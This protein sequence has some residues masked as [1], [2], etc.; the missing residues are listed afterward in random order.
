MPKQVTIIANPAFDA[1]TAADKKIMADMAKAGGR[2]VSYQTALENIRN[3]GG[4]YML[5]PDQEQGAAAAPAVAPSLQ[6]MPSRDLKIMMLQL[7]I[8]TEKQ[9]QRSDIIKLIEKKLDEVDVIEDD[10]TS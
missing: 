1:K 6:D 7:G 10:E 4:M 9:M 8:K 3:S 5:K 2:V